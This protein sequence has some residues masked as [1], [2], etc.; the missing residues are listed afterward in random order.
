[1]K[2]A[3]LGT[4]DRAALVVVRQLALEGSIDE[5]VIVRHT[6]QR[7]LACVSKYTHKSVYFNFDT[8]NVSTLIHLLQDEKIDLILPINDITSLFVIHHYS[9]LNANFTLASPTPS[10][11]YQAI[12]KWAIQEMCDGKTLKYPVSQLIE[13]GSR[14]ENRDI[15]EEYVYLKTR[16]SVVYHEEKYKKYDVQKLSHQEQQHYI[17]QHLHTIDV[18]CQK[19]LHGK[20]I[21]INVLAS[22]GRVISLNINQRIHQPKN[23]GGSSY[24]RTAKKIPLSL[25]EIATQI[26]S[27]LHWS[28]VMMIE[29]LETQEGFYLIEINP[30]FWG[31]LAL[32]EFSGA[33]FVRNF[34]RLQAGKKLLPSQRKE[35]TARHLINDLKWQVRNPKP[36]S[37]LTFLLSPLRVALRYEQYDVE[38]IMDPKPALYQIT[39]LTKQMKEKYFQH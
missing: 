24:R 18:I 8:P 5:V 26:T 30:R 2:V 15:S 13:Q 36:R 9:S 14:L 34:Y 16:N 37:L 27:R 21:G 22:K 39:L 23:G 11:Y 19:R 10:S 6:K 35:V 4:N 20:G 3:V 12:D 31:S 7:S 28:G 38:R 17:A 25:L 1:M 33:N 29:L 32:T